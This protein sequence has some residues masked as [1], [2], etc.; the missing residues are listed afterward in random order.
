MM[1]GW[2]NSKIEIYSPPYLFKGSRPTIFNSPDIV[3]HG[4]TFTIDT[5]E[6]SEIS[7]V[8][9]VRP[10]AVTHQ[11]DSEQRVIELLPIIHISSTQLELTA[12]DGGHPHPMAPRGHY[13]M[14]I[15]NNSNIPSEAKWI[16]LH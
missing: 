14:F 1:A 4:S 2:Y 15:I 16:Y 9:F 12:P 3:H 13:M 7:K 6:A 8:V 10:M 11:T 5:P